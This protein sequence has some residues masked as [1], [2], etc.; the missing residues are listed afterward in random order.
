VADDALRRSWGSLS[1]ARSRGF[2]N[3][4]DAA[5]AGSRRLLAEVLAR[6][7]RGRELR[8]LDLGC[9]NAQLYTYF[10]SA[11]LSC[12]YTGVDYSE[13]LLEAAREMHAGDS[14]AEFVAGDVITLQGIDQH[15]DVAIFSHVIEMLSSPQEALANAR[16]VAD[17]IAIRFFEPPEHEADVVELRELDAGDGRVVPY[18]RRKIS[19]DHYRLML[20]RIGCTSVDVYRDETS[21]DQ[22]HL[23]RFA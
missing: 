14:A 3:T 22:V 4:E 7:G 16:R 6:L 10:R 8:L 20:T 23:L 13:P 1:T 17:V 12:H 2:L 5:S 9:G 15:Y 18:L 11:G 21:T 19:R